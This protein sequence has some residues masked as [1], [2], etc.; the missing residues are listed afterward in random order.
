MFMRRSSPR[1]VREALRGFSLIELMVAMALSLLVLGAVAWLFAGSSGNRNEVERTG[2]L[3]ENAAYAAEL[4]TEEIRLAGYYAE[5]TWAGVAWNAPDPCT[6]ALGGLGWSQAPFTAPAPIVGYTA[7]DPTPA[8]IPDRKP[9]TA[10]VVLR[11]VSADTTPIALASGAPFLQVSKCNTDPKTWV[12]SD[13]PAD[14]TLHNLDCATLADIRE[15]VVRSYYIGCD[16][17]CADRTLPVLK[18]ADLVGNA[19]EITALVDG[20][21]D[22]ELEY[23]FD[24][25][26]DGD[27]D[28]YR[29]ALSGTAGAA[30]NDW[31]NVMSARLYLRART[32]DSPPGENDSGKSYL[33]P[34]GYIV[35]TGADTAYKRV[36][37][38]S[39]VRLVNPSGWR[40]L[41]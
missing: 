28:I 20:I 34:A 33:T 8:C 18:R 40:E 5:M 11:R 32:T 3:A 36:N 26:N 12:F 23:G 7:A 1:T 31:S 21:E 39:V 25:N 9:G 22:L 19:I 38:V 29:V 37:L 41:P 17:G 15:T 4:L 13:N 35:P 6:T 30:D 27:P 2:R 14:F 24:T 10:M 16:N